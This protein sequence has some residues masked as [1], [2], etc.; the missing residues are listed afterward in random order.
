MKNTVIAG[1]ALIFTL[2]FLNSCASPV[3]EK[4]TWKIIGNSIG[5]LSPKE[6]VKI[7]LEASINNRR[8]DISINMLDNSE[9]VCKAG[10]SKKHIKIVSIKINGKAVKV[11]SEC[12]NGR[13]YILPET[14]SGKRYL[15]SAVA[16]GNGVV[17]KTSFSPLLHYP[18]TDLNALR[19]KLMSE[20][21]ALRNEG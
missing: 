6:K 3:V 2:M 4:G 9:T 19:D 16:S 13:H 8:G 14:T 10:K 5:I 15:N 20:Q 12:I 17:I 7:Y 18:G 21:R 1:I 11:K